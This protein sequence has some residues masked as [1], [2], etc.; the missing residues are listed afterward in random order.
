MLPISIVTNFNTLFIA[1]N[2]PGVQ[3]EVRSKTLHV[4]FCFCRNL[5]NDEEKV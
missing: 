5:H 2:K 1:S 3:F 4:T